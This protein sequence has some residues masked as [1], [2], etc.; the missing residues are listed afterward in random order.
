MII[1]NYEI[2]FDQKNII[3]NANKLNYIKTIDNIK[4]NNFE[5]GYFSVVNNYIYYKNSNNNLRNTSYLTDTTLRYKIETPLE[6]IKDISFCKNYGLASHN[7]YFFK[8]KQEKIKAIGGQHFGI[9]SYQDDIKINNNYYKEYHSTISFIDATSYNLSIPGYHAIYNHTQPCPYYA[10][11]LHLFAEIN[12]NLVCLNNNLPIISGVH[13]GRYDAYYGYTNNLTLESSRNGLTVYDSLGSII[14]NKEKDLYYLYH[15]ANIGYSRRSIQYTTSKNL[16]EWSE[17]N[18]V[19]FGSEHEYF[20]C[21][22]YYSNFFN[23]PNTNIY[24]AILPYIKRVASCYNFVDSKEEY[25]LY[26]SYDCINYKYVGNIHENINI[27][28]LEDNYLS[29]NLPYYFNNNMYFYIFNNRC[30]LD[31]YTMEKNRY[32]FIT[33]KTIDESFFKIKLENILDKKI[34]INLIVDI[35]GYL[36]AELLDQNKNPIKNFTFNNFDCVFN[37]DRLD[38]IISWNNNNCI[39]DNC[40]YISFKFKNAKIYSIE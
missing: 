2:I 23:V 26:Y 10:N 3:I 17:F 28:T 35:D 22:M 13:P 18:I 32:M 38:L 27:K 1:L 40:I 31:V 14:Y 29:T 5:F 33:N 19:N 15:R 6:L 7:M 8:D 39:P 30:N 24:L 12:N 21:N 36:Y 37:S 11:G 9:V 16:L 25:R 4:D 34:K 20:E